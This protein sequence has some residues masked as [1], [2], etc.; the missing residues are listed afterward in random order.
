MLLVGD[1]G[2]DH[3]VVYVYHNNIGN[4]CPTFNILN[5]WQTNIKFN[6][7]SLN[8]KKNFFN[9]YSSDILNIDH[10]TLID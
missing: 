2:R 10:R 6:N 9:L 4:F 3:G 1:P 5:N 8:L 7:F